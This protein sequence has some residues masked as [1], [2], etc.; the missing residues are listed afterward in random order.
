LAIGCR[1][2]LN[3]EEAKS[4]DAFTPEDKTQEPDD[5]WCG[6]I[7]NE[8]LQSQKSH[9]ERCACGCVPAIPGL[10]EMAELRRQAKLKQSVKS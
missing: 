4:K 9:G 7:P 8:S 2:N 3:A 1:L 5:I 6:V 10:F